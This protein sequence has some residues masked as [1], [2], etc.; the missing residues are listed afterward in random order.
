MAV[1]SELAAGALF[2][3][4]WMLPAS[5]T[6]SVGAFAVGL[7]ALLLYASYLVAYLKWL[8]NPESP[9]AN[10]PKPTKPSSQWGMVL[11]TALPCVAI[12][13]AVWVLTT[14]SSPLGWPRDDVMA[15]AVGWLTMSGTVQSVIWYYTAWGGPKAPAPSESGKDHPAAIVDQTSSAVAVSEF[16]APGTTSGPEPTVESVLLAAEGLEP[17]AEP[18][19]EATPGSD[20]QGRRERENSAG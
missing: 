9:S 8:R 5:G 10:R 20:G 1:T 13:A 6:R 3:T 4:L 14:P 15:A 18:A 7:A 12:G 19:N 16:N 11:A 2:A 17:A